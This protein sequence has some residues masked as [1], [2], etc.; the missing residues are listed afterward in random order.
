MDTRWL[1]TEKQ[2]ISG[3]LP[4]LPTPI[5]SLL[6]SRGISSLEELQLFLNPPHKLPHDL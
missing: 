6:A 1:L 3:S 4:G 2:H 5:K